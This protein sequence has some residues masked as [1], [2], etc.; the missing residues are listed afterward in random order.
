MRRVI[1][2]FAITLSLQLNGQ[3]Y[4]R[5]NA[6]L[7][8]EVQVRAESDLRDYIG[9]KS[10]HIDSALLAVHNHHTIADLLS[11]NSM[12]HIKSYGSGGLATPSFR[13]TG[14]SH[15]QVCWNDINLNSPMLG[16]FDLAL[17]P[18]GFID[19]VNIYYGAGSMGINSGGFG[20]VI[21]LETGVSRGSGT[22]IT[23]NPGMGSFGRFSGL[24][25]ASTGNARLRSE[26]RAFMSNA[27]NDFSYINTV[28]EDSPRKERRENSEVSSTGFIQELHLS[29]NHNTLS[30]RVWYQSALRNLPVPITSPTVNPPE[31]QTDESFRAMFSW[32]NDMFPHD[33]ALTA[34]FVSDRLLYTNQLASIRSVNNSR[35]ITIKGN[36][37]RRINEI[38][39]MEASLNDELSMVTTSNYLGKI[40]RNLATLD[41]VTESVPASWISARLL[42]RGLLHDDKLLNPDFSLSTEYR[43]FSHKYWFLKA[44]IS[45]NSRVPTL[46]DMY[47]SPGGNRDLK[48]ESGTTAEL[49]WEMTN[50]R[51]SPFM[52]KNDITFFRNNIS[53]LIQWRPGSLSW[54]EAVNLG[55]V[56]TSG[57]ETGTIMSF[58]LSKVSLSLNAGYVYTKARSK[59]RNGES[60]YPAGRQLVYVPENQLNFVLMMNWKKFHAAFNTD[61]T[62]RRYLTADNS[63]YLPQYAVSGINLG[64]RLKGTRHSTDF[65]LSI[66][67]L[68]DASYQN[69]AYYPMPGRNLFLSVSYQFK[70]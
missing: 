45:K 21:D 63:V 19:G 53:N 64:A 58:S 44:S 32:L 59:E 29:D 22:E 69:M 34:A 70:K 14:P 38:L 47:W 27:R 54:W 56:M 12:I 20:G 23:I 41:L 65:S 8:G 13:G 48:N 26:T 5:D 66:E 62:G 1:L 67:N 68:F 15:T 46:N 11:G 2:F 40:T 25:K 61:Y 16:Q 50:F 18:A 24:L 4:H 28:A 60:T 57:L 43:P 7:I 37:K 39:T 36:Y 42:L 55:S 52:L 51:N 10:T 9:F 35:K 31:T 30:A 33:L 3:D 17:I 49:T 6:I